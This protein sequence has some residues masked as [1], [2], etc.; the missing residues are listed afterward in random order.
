MTMGMRTNLQIGCW[1]K[2]AGI[3]PASGERLDLLSRLSDAAFEAIKII[4]LEKSGIRDGDGCWHGSDVIGTMASELTSL[5][6][7]LTDHS[8]AEWL[9]SHPDDPFSSL[10]GGD[11]VKAE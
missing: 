6:K 4:E 7:Q 11:A 10:F 3:E 2:E 1:Q 8:R 9:K 5:C